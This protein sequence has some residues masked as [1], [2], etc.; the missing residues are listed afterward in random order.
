M[1]GMPPKPELN[2]YPKQH[3][4][5]KETIFMILYKKQWGLTCP[6]NNMPYQEQA[7]CG[8]KCYALSRY[9]GGLP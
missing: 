2:F 1:A 6:K 9:G 7:S 3:Q 8:R 4:P 5:L